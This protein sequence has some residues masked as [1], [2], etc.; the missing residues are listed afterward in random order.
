LFI[1]NAETLFTPSGT[2]G[3]QDIASGYG[4]FAHNLG[5]KPTTVQ[6]TPSG[7]VSFAYVVSSNASNIT[8]NT[9]TSATVGI[10]WNAWK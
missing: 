7:A 10:F 8:V 5:Q 6:V 2:R 9:S 3:Y 4:S 1:S